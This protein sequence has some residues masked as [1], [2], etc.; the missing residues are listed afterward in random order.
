MRITFWKF[1]L[2][3]LQVG[4]KSGENCQKLLI[5]M[6]REYL[7][8][9]YCKGYGISIN[10]LGILLKVFNNNTKKLSE[11]VVEELKGFTI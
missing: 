5:T 6:E 4:T 9:I 11:T 3:V 8:F 1:S 7:I 10:F 2:T